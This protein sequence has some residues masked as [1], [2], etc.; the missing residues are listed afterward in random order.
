MIHFILAGA[1]SLVSSTQAHATSYTI[2]DLG[3]LDGGHESRAAAINDSG[4]VVGTAGTW[5]GGSSAYYYDGSMNI[6]SPEAQQ[7]YDINNAGQI[8]GRNAYSSFIYDH[9]TITT[10]DAKVAFGINESGQ[11]VGY[12]QD[13]RGYLYE[14]NTMTKMFPDGRVSVPRKIND[15]GVAVGSSYGDAFIYQNGQLQYIEQLSGI[16]G[17]PADIN[18]NGQICGYFQETGMIEK[19][20][21]LTNGDLSIFDFNGYS[22]LMLGM[23]DYGAMVGFSWKDHFIYT[24]E[25]ALMID[26]NGNVI[27]LNALN[28]SG[29]YF[30]YLLEAD[31]INNHGQIVGSG[32]VGG[33][34]HAFLLSPVPT[35]EPGTV[36]LVCSGLAGLVAV[37]RRKK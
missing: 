3:T 8:V 6:I 16:N 4:I 10:I 24:N 20:F 11:V 32:L 29:D 37:R 9:G 28:I 15:H 12:D 17:A 23:N 13:S 5:G 34:Q 21:R 18:N 2:V 1:I 19:A 35:P 7:A 22:T 36:W 25:T 30:D 26:E 27:D 31:D 33:K 14:N